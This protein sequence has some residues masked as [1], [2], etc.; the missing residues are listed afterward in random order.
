MPKKKDT[1]IQ[2]L[3]HMIP[4]LKMKKKTLKKKSESPKI[5]VSEPVPP[6]KDLLNSNQLSKKPEPLLPETLLKL[7]TEL[8]VFS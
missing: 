5:M 6:F 4:L 7:P 1:M 3:F 8:L 2:K